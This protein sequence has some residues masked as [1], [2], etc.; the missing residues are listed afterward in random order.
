MTPHVQSLCNHGKSAHQIRYRFLRKFIRFTS[1]VRDSAD[2]VV[3]AGKYRSWFWLCRYD[4]AITLSTIVF[5]LT[6]QHHGAA[7]T[8]PYPVRVARWSIAITDTE[9]L[10]QLVT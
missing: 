7:V 9:L 6:N 10:P 8:F 3:P 2:L 4:A 1:W 5:A